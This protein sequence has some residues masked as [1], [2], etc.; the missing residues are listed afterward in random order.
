MAFRRGTAE[1]LLP[2]AP[3]LDE[4]PELAQS[5][6]QPRPRMDV[7]RSWTP[8]ARVSR[9]HIPPEELGRPPVVANGPVD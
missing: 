7:G 3:A 2:V 9:L 8:C 1:R 6:C 4:L 5:V